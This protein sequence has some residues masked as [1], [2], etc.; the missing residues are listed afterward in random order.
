MEPGIWRRS[1]YCWATRK[2]SPR[3]N[4]YVLPKSQT[5]SQFLAPSISDVGISRSGGTLTVAYAYGSALR[6]CMG[7]GC[8]HCRVASLLTRQPIS[9]PLWTDVKRECTASNFGLFD[10]LVG[11]GK[12]GSRD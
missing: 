4:F 11:A 5:R 1:G 2:S 12:Q 10:H 3:R 6:L 8:E 9:G 7:N